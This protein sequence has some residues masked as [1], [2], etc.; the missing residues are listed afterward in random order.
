MITHVNGRP[1]IESPTAAPLVKE[2][3]PAWVG[4]MILSLALFAGPALLALVI[5]LI[6]LA[7]VV[8]GG[9]FSLFKSMGA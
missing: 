3:M 5:G 6:Y 7:A 9:C 1:R 8:A 4:A 2:N